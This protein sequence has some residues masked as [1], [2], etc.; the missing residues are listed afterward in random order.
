[1]VRRS[2]P[3]AGHAARLAASLTVW[4]VITPSTPGSYN[5]L[6]RLPALPSP[7]LHTVSVGRD[8]VALAVD[9]RAGRV[10]VLGSAGSVT[11]LDATTGVVMRSVAVGRGAQSVVA[12]EVTGRAFVTDPGRVFMLD[13][14]TGAVLRAISVGGSGPTGGLAVDARHGEVFVAVRGVNHGPAGVGPGS[15]A[16]L[17]AATGRTRRTIHADANLLAVDGVARRIIVPQQCGGDTSTSDACADTLDAATGHRLKRVDF[18]GEEGFTQ[19]TTAVAVD[20]RAGRAFVLY[21]DG[22]GVSDVGVLATRTGIGQGTVGGAAGSLGTIAVDEQ[23]GRIVIATAPDSYAAASGTGPRRTAVVSVLDTR[24]GR[25]L[26]NTTVPTA[27]Q[28]YVFVPGAVADQRRGRFYVVATLYTTAAAI[29]PRSI[30]DVFAA[31]SG[32]LL[33]TLTLP[34]AVGQPNASVGPAMAVDGRTGRLF[35]TSGGNNT[36]SV[37]DTAHL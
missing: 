26:A 7:V 25:N 9:E 30:L 29:L 22:R 15:V 21:G 6:Q 14:R 16:V 11:T 1:M 17:D 32:R 34:T 12:D 20:A 3:I 33:R 13:V 27:S 37:L 35:I 10:F 24:T 36:V 4:L 18:G 19:Q 28:A 23:A 8:P 31:S 2:C 5:G